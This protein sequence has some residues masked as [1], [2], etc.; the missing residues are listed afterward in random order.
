MNEQLVVLFTYFV[1]A[2]FIGFEV[3]SKVPTILHTPLMSGSNAIHGIILIGA[4]LIAAHAQILFILGLL[5]LSSPKGARRGNWVAA[6]GMVL[7]VGWTVVILHNSF[8]PAGIAISAAG[9]VV[10]SLIGTLAARTVK[11][12]AMP[13][14]VA[15]FNGVGGGAAS[16]V[17]LSELLNLAGSHL[18]FQSSVP[19]VFALIIGGISFAG[20]G[21]AFAKLQELMTGTPLTFPGQHIVNGLLALVILALAGVLLGVTGSVVVLIVLLALALVL[22]VAFVLPIG[23]ADMPVVISLLNACT[24]LAVAASGFAL[25]NFALVW[26][27]RPGS[28]RHKREQQGGQSHGTRWFS[29]RHRHAAGLRALCDHRAWLRTCRGPGAACAA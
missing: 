25:D 22:G 19:S 21:I 7:A 11:M 10:G 6:M 3:I 16:L 24:G 12:T 20:S 15:I 9:V 8:T 5:Y 27:L 28:D 13:Q 1:L 29:G 26:R 2:I 23:G 14:M 18:E 4:L 17:A